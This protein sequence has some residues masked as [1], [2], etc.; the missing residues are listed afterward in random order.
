MLEEIGKGTMEDSRDQRF[1]RDHSILTHS[2]VVGTEKPFT[3]VTLLINQ[4]FRMKWF[5]I[6]TCDLKWFKFVLFKK[7][8]FSP[9]FL[10]S[11]LKF[12]HI[13]PQYQTH[14]DGKNTPSVS[15]HSVS[16]ANASV[17]LLNS[18]EFF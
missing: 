18:Q 15:P 5:K 16:A 11:L 13:S 3:V 6:V 12:I 8:D 4:L 2:L 7:Q 17:V 10:A 9:V 14:H 1:L